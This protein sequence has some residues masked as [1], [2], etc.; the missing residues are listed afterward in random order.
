[1]YLLLA[2]CKGRFQLGVIDDAAE[3]HDAILEAL[4][5]VLVGAEEKEKEGEGGREKKG[6]ESEVNRK[7]VPMDTREDGCGKEG[8]EQYFDEVIKYLPSTSFL[9]IHHDDPSLSF[10]MTS[11]SLPLS[12][13]L[14]LSLTCSLY[15]FFF[16][17]PRTLFFC[18][19]LR[20]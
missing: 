4:H 5:S 14:C 6:K 20:L 16:F 7:V 13:S 3:A 17:A 12:L 8:E 19:V 9:R 11:P 1:L 15:V 2:F 18:F 10:G